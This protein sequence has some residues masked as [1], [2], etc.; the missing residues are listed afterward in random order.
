MT[1]F[2]IQTHCFNEF[3]KKTIACWSAADLPTVLGGGVNNAPG[4]VFVTTFIDFYRKYTIRNVTFLLILTENKW[5]NVP[6]IKAHCTYIRQ[7]Y[8]LCFVYFIW[9]KPN[10]QNFLFL[11]L[12]L[13]SLIENKTNKMSC[14]T[15]IT[16]C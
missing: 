10:K 3:W 2:H 7:C 5:K 4:S 9:K 11:L 16:S 14:C 1:T 15:Y 13:L 6:K 8:V 12:V